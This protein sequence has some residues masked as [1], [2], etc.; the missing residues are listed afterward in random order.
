MTYPRIKGPKT[1]NVVEYLDYLDWGSW[2]NQQF[3]I[4]LDEPKSSWAG[5][6]TGNVARKNQY[7]QAVEYE[8]ELA[9]C[10]ITEPAD[11]FQSSVPLQGPEF[12]IDISDTKKTQLDVTLEPY[13]INDAANCGTIDYTASTSS[14]TDLGFDAFI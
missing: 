5:I 13:T 7:K 11:Q 2:D 3:T 1:K 9:M 12:S 4:K 10:W 6:Y 8:F 14:S